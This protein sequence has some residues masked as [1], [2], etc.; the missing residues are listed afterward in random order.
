[1]NSYDL[2][3]RRILA[4]LNAPV[5]EIE[6]LAQDVFLRVFRNLRHFRGQSSFYT[7]LYRITL[8]VFFD[9]NKKQSRADARIARL[10]RAFDRRRAA[11]PRWKTR[12]ASAATRCW[13]GR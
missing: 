10:Q 12:T 2:H 13:S 8:N 1:M 4:Q 7:W 5:G 6:D 3:V 11:A 9:F